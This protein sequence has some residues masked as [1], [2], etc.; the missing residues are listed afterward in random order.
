MGE[1]VLL[2]TSGPEKMPMLR[3]EGTG[4]C[5]DFHFWVLLSLSTLVM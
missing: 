1:L 5:V 2:G 3:L 4:S